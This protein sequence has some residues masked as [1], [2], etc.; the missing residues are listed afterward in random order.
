MSGL[1]S[2]SNAFSQVPR[3]APLSP[4]QIMHGQMAFPDDGCPGLMTLGQT[5]AAFQQGQ[6]A[7]APGAQ[8]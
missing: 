5:A 8:G 6:A 7:I 1:H 2:F 3:P 4:G